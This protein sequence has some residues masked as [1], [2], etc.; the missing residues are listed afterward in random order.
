MPLLQPLHRPAHPKVLPLPRLGQPGPS[1]GRLQCPSESTDPVPCFRRPAVVGVMEH[2]G[3]QPTILTACSVTCS[4]TLGRCSCHHGPSLGRPR[5]NN[6]PRFRGE[7]HPAG[8]LRPARPAGATFG[9]S[10]PSSRSWPRSTTSPPTAGRAALH[11]RTPCV[12]SAPSPPG[13]TVS[14]CS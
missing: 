10:P 8:D 5:Q 6:W 3:A 4:G 9:G 13:S 11:A 14:S 2:P 12:R 1:S 7:S